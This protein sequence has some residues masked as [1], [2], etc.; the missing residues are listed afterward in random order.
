MSLGRGSMFF[1]L[2]RRGLLGR[3]GRP[4]IACLALTIAATIVTAMLNIYLGL[5]AKI[6]QEFRSYGANVTIAAASGQE[7][8]LDTWNKIQ[9]LLPPGSLSAPFAFA[10]AHTSSG[11]PIVVAGADMQ[12]V[13][14]L[15]R[16][17]LVSQWP[18]K[19][20]E[21]LVGDK[22]ASH[23]DLANGSFD[24]VFAGRTLH[25]KEAGTLK[26]GSQEED[27]VYLPLAVFESW[28][29][30]KPSLIELSVSSPAQHLNAVIARLQAALPEAQV[31]PVRQ[32]LATETPVLQHMKSVILAS[33]LLIAFTVGLC[34]FA[35]LTSSVL[36]R[37]RDFAVMKAIGSSQFMI[38]SLF[39]GEAI[40]LAIVAAF[41]GYALGS[42]IAAWIAAVN[43]QAAV[44]PQVQVLWQ[45]VLASVAL[46][47]LAALAPLGQL[48]QIQPAGILKGE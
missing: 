33:T 23:L 22:A 25:L 38:D 34:V 43:F 35:T 8:P 37:R 17:W 9:P 13:Q 28:T 16:W 15:D 12:A 3:G 10:V 36:E 44:H 27:R 4:W 47:L 48:Q 20:G 24:L 32:L 1:H 29:R 6:T 42:G 40:C 7:L 45:V 41:V 2:L 26:T 14:R 21:A 19:D 30:V 5:E 31:R 18:M 39:A 11:E 46:A